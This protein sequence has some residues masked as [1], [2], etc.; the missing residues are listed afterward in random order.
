MT[1]T[2]AATP[3]STASSSA[4]VADSRR[5]ALGLGLQLEGLKRWREDLA[6]LIA[7]YQSWIEQQGLADGEADLA[8]YQL[9]EQLKSDKLVVALAGEFSRGKTELINALFF[10]DYKQRLLPSTSGRTTMCPTEVLYDDKQDPY[11]RLLPIE[12]R[13]TTLTIGEYKRTPVHWTTIHLHK[14]GSAQ[15]VAEAFKEIV[16]TKRV[17]LREAHELGL[18]RPALSDSPVT[19]SETIEVPVWRHAVVNFPHPLLQSGLVVLDTPG[20]NALGTEPE[21]TTSL[22]PSAHAVLF[23]I[24]ADVGVTRTDLD[25]WR[26][27]V[28]PPTERQKQGRL[29]VLNKIDLMWDA[30]REPQAIAD[31]IARQREETANHLGIP[32]EAV[33]PVSASA[34]LVAKSK[35]D[36]ALLEQSGIAVLEQKIAQ[37]LL[38]SRQAFLREKVAGAIGARIKETAAM[39]KARLH[40]TTH[41]LDQL[42]LLGGKN[43]DF[44]QKSVQSLRV[45]RERYDKEVRSF[46]ATRG[47]LSEQAKILLSHLS[48]AEFDKLS[49]RARRDMKDSWTTVGLKSGMDSLVQG[50]NRAMDAALKQSERMTDLM[51]K[52]YKRFQSEHGL[53]A[54]ELP[55]FDLTTYRAA[56]ARFTEQAEEFRNSPVTAITEQHFVIK[57]FFIGVVSQA[58][59]LVVQLNDAAKGWCRA[60][61]QPVFA[62]IQGHKAAMDRRLENLKHVQ[63]NLDKLG[64]KIAQLERERRGFED[65]L[66]KLQQ[67]LARLAAPAG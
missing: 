46:E 7:D 54:L 43:V 10:S 36:A 64:E 37:D 55:A 63:E 21:L 67:M 61:M 57:K 42:K 58:R 1:A 4:S 22:M 8:V 9:I 65:Q 50:L 16:R 15:D 47:L 18:Y 2:L 29:A 60:A 38:P 49:Q 6:A 52:A 56:L 40:E 34:A 59:E 48:Q 28:C 51:A 30:L 11:I 17:S 20:L 45:E 24:G 32:R 12:T 53:S 14:I 66:Q 5:A 62:E 27:Y 44:I 13:K 41:E 19:N 23:M 3:L 35:H 31:S 33:F 26:R 25:A 39:V